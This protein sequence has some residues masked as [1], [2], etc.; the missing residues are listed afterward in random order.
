MPQKLFSDDNARLT[1]CHCVV[2]APSALRVT[3]QDLDV[4]LQID[5]DFCRR[6]QIG[7]S[8]MR[9]PKSCCLGEIN[10]QT[11]T[12][13]TVLSK[14]KLRYDQFPLEFVFTVSLGLFFFLFFL[15]LHCPPHPPP[16]LLLSF[17]LSL[18]FFFFFNCGLF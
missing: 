3:T 7:N 16:V 2:N 13:S 6:R 12:R 14:L 10:M 1:H 11:I 17:F 4:Q 18:F 15:L 5:V 9:P 8:G